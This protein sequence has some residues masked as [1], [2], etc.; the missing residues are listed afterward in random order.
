[1]EGI[2]LFSIARKICEWTERRTIMISSTIQQNNRDIII[3][4]VENS[5]LETEGQEIHERKWCELCT[6]HPTVDIIVGIVPSQVTS[7]P[8]L[9]KHNTNAPD[10]IS[11]PHEKLFII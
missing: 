10:C 4:C 2:Q 6:F 5:A 8:L 11:S 3:L 7:H 9:E 1:M